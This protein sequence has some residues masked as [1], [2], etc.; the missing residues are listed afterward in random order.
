[1]TNSRKD[2]ATKPKTKTDEPVPGFPL[3]FTWHTGDWQKIFDRQTELI[4]K[5]VERARLDGR[6]VLYL[7][8]PISNRGGGFAGTNVDIAHYVER[9]IL[10]RW[11]EAFWVLNPAKYQ[12]ESKAGKGLLDQHAT[13]LKL[14]IDIDKLE[15]AAPPGGGDYLRMWT[16]SL[17]RMV[18]KISRATSMP[19]TSSGRATSSPSSPKTDRRA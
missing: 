14:G 16:R 18:P 9:K 5:D 8:C 13:E 3:K 12:L 17:S 15:Q 2:A 11:G 7:S 19:S 4:K 6:L 1:M 10:Q